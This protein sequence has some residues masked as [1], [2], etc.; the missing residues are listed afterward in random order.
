MAHWP[1]DDGGCK[2]RGRGTDRKGADGDQISSLCIFSNLPLKPETL[3]QAWR[4]AGQITVTQA[5]FLEA[6]TWPFIFDR[7]VLEDVPLIGIPLKAGLPVTERV[8]DC[9]AIAIVRCSGPAVLLPGG[10]QVCK[11]DGKGQRRG[12]TKVDGPILFRELPGTPALSFFDLSKH[13]RCVCVL[14]PALMAAARHREVYT[15]WPLW[16]RKLFV[17]NCLVL[18]KL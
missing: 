9:F 2:A 4:Y 10:C 8:G 11:M 13:V 1:H 17:K 14:F 6:R 15:N 12:I 5:L 7:A 16:R 3:E 18:R